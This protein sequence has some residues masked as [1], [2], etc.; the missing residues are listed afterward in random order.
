MKAFFKLLHKSE[1][2]F[3]L[4]WL[5]AIALNMAEWNRIWGYRVSTP[6]A[7]R[8][9]AHKKSLWRREPQRLNWAFSLKHP[10]TFWIMV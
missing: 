8:C 4:V 6:H 5:V 1:W 2:Y 3:I 10:L 9:L 7:V